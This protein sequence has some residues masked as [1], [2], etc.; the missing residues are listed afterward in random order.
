[1]QQEVEVVL[2]VVVQLLAAAALLSEVAVAAGLDCVVEGSVL[3]GEAL[4][5]PILLEEATE[6]APSCPLVA[7]AA[8]VVE[9]LTVRGLG[10]LSYRSPATEVARAVVLPPHVPRRHLQLKLVVSLV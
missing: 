6:G 4:V 9:A 5:A 2:L 10:L 7:V 3:R 8:V 1:M